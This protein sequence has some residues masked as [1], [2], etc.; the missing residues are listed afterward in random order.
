VPTEHRVRRWARDARVDWITGA[1][2]AVFVVLRLLATL[3]RPI[4]AFNDTPSYFDFRLW[5]GVRFPV[6]TALYSSVG[7]HRAIVVLQAV[8][9]ALGWSAAAVVAGSVLERRGA[10]YGFQAMVL[11]LGLTLP[12]TRFDN[13]LLSESVAISSTVVLVACVLRY[14]CR[15]TTAMALAVL[16]VGIVWALSRQ[17]H[18]FVL[19]VAAA[20]LAVVGAGRADRR[21]AWRL[22]AA[23]LAVGLVGVALASSTAQIQEYNTAQIL[24]RR[25][26]QDPAR[27]RWF[28]DRG[29]PDNGDAL[30]VPP[31]E[32]RFGDP[33]VE[34]QEDPTFGPWLRDDFP[35]TY[36]RYLVLHP[37]YTVGTPFG[38]QGALVPLATGTPD[39]GSSRAVLPEVVGT[40]F[41]PHGPGER[42]L[43]GLLVVAVL[44]AGATGA[45]R[46]RGRRRAFAG[47][48]G[49]VLVAVGNLV[50][51]THTAGWEYERLLVP[52][53]VAV[54]FA[55]VWLVAATVGGV[56]VAPPASAPPDP[57]P[58][59]RDGPSSDPA[60][61]GAPCTS[62]AP[63]PAGSSSALAGDPASGP[64]GTS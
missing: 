13:A 10:R 28:L 38:R 61:S 26:L 20:V 33:A 40:L 51:V 7:D 62:A 57:P 29:M 63:G 60:G 8:A 15:P 59:R 23:L 12:V 4:A 14:S 24:V 41:W 39:Y 31:Y 27:E 48:G 44:V 2:I 1:L 22:A 11:A 34:L 30:L 32:N 25:V 16:G 54:R 9:G 6:V 19:V 21:G 58:R 53:G 36:L 17:N 37:G 50:F 56:S 35:G 18:A 5:G 46:S 3:G 42:W 55:L 49:V 52:T 64:P 47:A 45:V 43:V